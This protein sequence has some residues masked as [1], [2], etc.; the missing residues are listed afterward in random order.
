MT[1]SSLDKWIHASDHH[2]S[3]TQRLSIMIDVALA[4]EYLHHGYS[5]PIIHHD[6]KPSNVLLNDDMVAHATRSRSIDNT[7]Q[8]F[9]YYWIHDSR[10]RIRRLSLNEIDVYSYGIL[11]M[12]TFSRKKPTDSM[13]EADI[14]LKHWIHYECCGGGSLINLID[15]KLLNEGGGEWSTFKEQCFS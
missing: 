15:P 12:E 4:I 6:L 14:S 1:N 2:L 8:Q 7:E 9:G 13:F 10:I 5:T 11:L 3:F